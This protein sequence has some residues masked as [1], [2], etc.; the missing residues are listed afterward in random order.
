MVTLIK[1]LEVR[2][3]WCPDESLLLLWS[4]FRCFLHRGWAARP[5]PHCCTLM[6][7]VIFVCCWMPLIG[8]LSMS[9]PS[10]FFNTAQFASHSRSVSACNTTR[11]EAIHVQYLIY[12]AWFSRHNQRLLTGI[13]KNNCNC[14]RTDFL[15]H[16]W[17]RGQQGSSFCKSSHSSLVH[18]Q[19]GRIT[20]PRITSPLTNQIAL[21]YNFFV[22]YMSIV[23]PTESYPETRQHQCSAT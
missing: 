3:P 23:D 9:F 8:L 16:F 19:A 2:M 12:A 18:G 22:I 6:N 4:G 20:F 11:N 7:K 21:F 5:P 1:D 17:P 10:Y 13:V 14:T 15:L